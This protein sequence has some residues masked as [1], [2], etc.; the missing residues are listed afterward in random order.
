[1]PVCRL[2]K[3]QLDESQG[4]TISFGELASMR[5]RRGDDEACSLVAAS[6]GISVVVVGAS[7]TTY[8]LCS[9]CLCQRVVASR[10]DKQ[11]WQFWK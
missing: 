10:P 9:R 4:R 8:W 6:F 5:P 3:L 1:M 11:W 2:C 7:E